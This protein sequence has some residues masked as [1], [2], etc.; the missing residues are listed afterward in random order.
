MKTSIILEWICRKNINGKFVNII[1]VPNEGDKE[2]EQN[3]GWWIDTFGGLPPF[4][5]AEGKYFF[6]YES[7][8]SYCIQHDGILYAPTAQVEIPVVNGY[9]YVYLYLIED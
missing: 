5:I 3:E 2:F 8:I 9:D 1:E 7:A 4:P 6:Y